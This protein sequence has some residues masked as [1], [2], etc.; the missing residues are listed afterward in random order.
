M[1][2]VN[3]VSWAGPAVSYQ[4]GDLIDLPDD[5]ARARVAAGLAEFPPEPEHE[6]PARRRRLTA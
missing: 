1:L 3:L 2:I 4:P 6:T 5:T